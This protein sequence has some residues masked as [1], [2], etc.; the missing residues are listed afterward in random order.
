[1]LTNN[2][3]QLLSEIKMTLDNANNAFTGITNTVQQAQNKRLSVD[4][5]T[6]DTLKQVFQHLQDH[7]EKQG[8]ELLIT[9]PSDLF[10]IDTSYIHSNKTITLIL[11]V[12]MVT[13][14]NKQTCCNSSPYHYLSHLEQKPLLHQKSKRISS[15]WE[16]IISTKS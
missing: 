16:N 1:M 5:L 14:D 9:Q 13:E 3:A 6:P 4:L 12:P 2:P 11:H 15:Q 7:A 8:L 10:Q